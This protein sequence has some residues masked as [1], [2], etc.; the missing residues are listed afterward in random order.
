VRNGFEW[1][2]TGEI[3]L[4]RTLMFQALRSTIDKWD[5]L[6]LKRFSKAKDSVN[7]TKTAAYILGKDLH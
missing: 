7:Q 2:G 4:N 1:I 5:L 3:F 6:K